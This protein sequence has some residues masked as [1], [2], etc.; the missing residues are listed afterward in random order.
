MGTN[1]YRVP[2]SGEVIKKQQKFNIRLQ[3]LDW[4]NPSN[5]ADKFIVIEDPNDKWSKISPWDEFVEDMSVHLGKRSLGWKFCW[6]FHDNKYYSNKQE[7]LKFIRSGRI[8]DEY[9]RSEDVEEFIQMALKWGEPDGFIVDKQYFEKNEKPSY[10]YYQI[11]HTKVKEGVLEIFKR[12]PKYDTVGTVEQ[13]S[14]YL[15]TIFPDSKVKD[16]VYHGTDKQFNVFK[17][18]SDTGSKNRMIAFA[19]NIEYA[20]I[21]GARRTSLKKVITALVNI[22]KLYPVDKLEAMELDSGYRDEVLIELK[23][24]G[25]DGFAFESDDDL[26]TRNFNEILV[27]KPEQIH[28]LE[29]EQDIEAFKVFVSSSSTQAEQGLNLPEYTSGKQHFEKNRKSSYIFNN[30]ENYYDKI[31]DGL[32]VSSS[33][34]FS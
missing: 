5:A 17:K 34:D 1:Y 11:Q 31:I 15:D 26:A 3:E 20:K 28:I 19:D 13:Y 27:F 25:V 29:T 16:I 6:N 10:V 22:R 23:K 7:L 33:T 21:A 24:E 12:N 2:N 30:Q 4:W 8:V 14:A 32:R 18:P 9:G